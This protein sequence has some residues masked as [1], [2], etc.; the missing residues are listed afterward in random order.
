MNLARCFSVKEWKIRWKSEPEMMADIESLRLLLREGY[1]RC[2]FKFD[3][4]TKEDVEINDRMDRMVEIYWRAFDP[5]FV[6]LYK[7]KGKYGDIE[8]FESIQKS[9]IEVGVNVEGMDKITAIRQI[10]K[11]ENHSE[12]YATVAACL[13]HCRWSGSCWYLFK[14]MNSSACKGKKD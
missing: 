10:Q 8:S 5:V 6:R 7:K 12:C 4:L 14:K 1:H 2:N 13:E 11:A 9:A 3:L